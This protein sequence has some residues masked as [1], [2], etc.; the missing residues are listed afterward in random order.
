MQLTPVE[1]SHIA[2]IGY[3]ESDAVLLVRY[4]DGTVYAWSG[5]LQPAWAF[6]ESSKSKGTCLHAIVQD[7]PGTK[8]SKGGTAVNQSKPEPAGAVE[9]APL[10]VIDDAAAPCCRASLTASLAQFPNATVMACGSC[11]LSFHPQQIGAQRFWRVPPRLVDNQ[12]IALEEM[13]KAQKK[14]P[15]SEQDSGFAI[16]H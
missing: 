2:A 4:R 5:I 16:G 15:V 6:L 10:N 1:S 14:Q 11:G 3:L 8:I 13:I 7:R 12:R 9:A